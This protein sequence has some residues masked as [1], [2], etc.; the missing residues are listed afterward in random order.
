MHCGVI[1]KARMFGRLVLLSAT[2]LF[3]GV[4]E[5]CIS[6]GFSFFITDGRMCQQR[7]LFLGSPMH[8]SAMAFQFLSPTYVSSPLS[9]TH[10][11]TCTCLQERARPHACACVFVCI[12]TRID[13]DTL[14]NDRIGPRVLD[15]FSLQSHD[16]KARLRKR[17][18]TTT[19]SWPDA[20]TQPHLPHSTHLYASRC[21]RM[22]TFCGDGKAHLCSAVPRLCLL[23][24]GRL[25]EARDLACHPNC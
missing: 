15:G 5:V 9:H 10:I 16:S 12:E 1:R 6:D 23:R 4:T 17:L 24:P 14:W 13:T 20:P 25:D 8:V 11:C 19:P 3:F 21:T 7:L 2:A 22:H 18:Y